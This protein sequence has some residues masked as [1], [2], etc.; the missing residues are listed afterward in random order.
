MRTLFITFE[1]P[2]D[3][4]GSL[5][6]HVDGKKV[7]TLRN[8]ERFDAPLSPGRHIVR[9]VFGPSRWLLPLARRRVD[10]TEHALGAWVA[11]K[12][13]IEAGGDWTL[14]FAFRAPREGE[15][16]AVTVDLREILQAA[17]KPKKSA[18]APAS[19]SWRPYPS[20]TGGGKKS[21]PI[22][23]V[24]N[25]SP[26]STDTG[27]GMIDRLYP[28]AFSGDTTYSLALELSYTML[29][30]LSCDVSAGQRDFDFSWEFLCESPAG[31]PILIRES[32]NT[33]I[34]TSHPSGI[35]RRHLCT[36]EREELT[37][38]KAKECRERLYPLERQTVQLPIPLRPEIRDDAFFNELY[39]F[40]HPVKQGPAKAADHRWTVEVTK[41]DVHMA[42]TCGPFHYELDD[43]MTI[44]EFVEFVARNTLLGYGGWSWEIRTKDGAIGYDRVGAK[45]VEVCA[46]N[47]TLR[48]ARIHHAHCRRIE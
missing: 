17:E 13:R 33:G 5:S 38:A 2:E 3:V 19:L 35:L 28:P 9:A 24:K 7:C 46:P 18:P 36:I 10:N 48:E 47:V 12:Q 39:R 42:D 20:E 44:S 27:G 45:S 4:A 25:F 8:H 16:G 26:F 41:E 37:A 11:H 22:E 6:V 43:R 14:S 21:P 32:Y 23:A 29:G 34:D 40:S 30:A 1:Q 31:D 15:R